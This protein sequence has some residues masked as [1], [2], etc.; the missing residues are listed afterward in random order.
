[1]AI[2]ASAPA[3]ANASAA[4]D[5]DGHTSLTVMTRNMDEGTDFGYFVGPNAKPTVPEAVA[6]TYAEVLASG[7]PQRSAAMADEIAKARP[8][9]VSL[10]EASR[11]QGPA[12]PPGSGTVTLDALQFLQARLLADGAHYQV[13]TVVPEFSIGGSGLP[14]SFLDRDVIL[15]KQDKNSDE[16]EL[17]HVQSAHFSTLLTVPIPGLGPVTITRGW[18]SVDVEVDG[19]KARFI[20]T[21]LESFSPLVQNEQG[22]ELLNGPANTSL[23]VILAGDLNTGPNAANNPA[24]LLTYNTLTTQGGF[25][26]SWST[27]HPGTPGFTNALYNEDPFTPTPLSQRIDLVLLR[28]DISARSDKLVG[29]S[30][31]DGLWP[32]DH[33]GVVSKLRL[34][35]DD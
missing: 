30:K 19:G 10:Q 20:A 15:A 9:L 21:H 11:W 7:L 23:P 27:T 1:L 35:A 28:G 6:A 32:S 2:A 16:L 24:Q 8:A 14:V 3:V 25:V 5:G 29:E 34:S 26:D 31:I 18:A 12:P 22:L 4:S 17:S 33:L 13:V